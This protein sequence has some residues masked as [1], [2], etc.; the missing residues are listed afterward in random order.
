[1]PHFRFELDATIP[2]QIVLLKKCPWDHYRRIN[3]ASLV[4]KYSN[5][6]IRQYPRSLIKQGILYFGSQTNFSISH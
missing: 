1:M 6:P 2:D 3:M 4:L 5:V